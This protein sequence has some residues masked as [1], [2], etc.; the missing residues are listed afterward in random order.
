MSLPTGEQAGQA[1]RIL[2]GQVFPGLLWQQHAVTPSGKIAFFEKNPPPK[3][4]LIT[5]LHRLATLA[6]DWPLR[7]NPP[8]AN[9]PFDRTP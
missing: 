5:V 2:T 7:Y 3:R 9:V 4:F 8:L 6:L 1:G